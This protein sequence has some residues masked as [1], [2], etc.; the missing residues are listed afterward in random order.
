MLA[1]NR[2]LAGKI[3][4]LENRLDTHD[5]DIRD[6]I[7]AIKRLMAPQKSSRARI[8]FELPPGPLLSTATF[9]G[10]LLGGV[11]GAVVTTVAIF[12]PSFFYVAALGPVPPRLGRSPWMGAFLDGVNACAVALMAG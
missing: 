9:I 8:G 7:A 12:L 5:S 11:W 3:Y 10:Y 2:R 6:L 1:T 4:E